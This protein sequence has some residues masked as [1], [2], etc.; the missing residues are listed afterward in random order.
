[1]A[2]IEKYKIPRTQVDV[3]GLAVEFSNYFRITAEDLEALR[4]DPA[5]GSL[6]V[7]FHFEHVDLASSVPVCVHRRHP[8][9]LRILIWHPSEIR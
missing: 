5:C 9:P 2:S 3:E 7:L 6:L 1:M 4:Q 8:Q